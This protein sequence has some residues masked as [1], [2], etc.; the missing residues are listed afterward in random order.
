MKYRGEAMLSDGAPVVVRSLCARDA[1]E[2]LRLCRKAAG[3]TR[4]M[5]REPEEWTLT[6]RQQQEAIAKAEHD[7]CALMLGAFVQ[8]QL[9]G[10]LSLRPVHPALRA[11]HR[12][13]L[14]VCVL[15]AYWGRGIAS[16]MMQAAIC[17]AK[18]GSLEQL[19]L[20]VLT[21]NEAAIR[22]YRKMGF[23]ETGRRARMMKYRDGTYADALLMTLDLRAQ[24]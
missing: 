19:E 11:R 13:G 14:G 6:E 23:V 15:K 22:L 21:T 10:M 20:D 18:A 4:N 8:G 17:T 16:E 1:G 2:A 9:A 24:R 3:E 12:A 7:P 5:M